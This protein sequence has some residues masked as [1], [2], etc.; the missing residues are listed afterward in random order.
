[1][2]HP[3][4]VDPR[5]A[6]VVDGDL[7]GTAWTMALTIGSRVTGLSSVSSQYW[8]SSGYTGGPGKGQQASTPWMA[9]S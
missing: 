4:G 7:A 5:R 9:M 6:R 2:A 3:V 1:M 8:R